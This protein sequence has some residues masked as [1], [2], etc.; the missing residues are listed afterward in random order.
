MKVKRTKRIEGRGILWNG[1]E[2][3]LY[4]ASRTSKPGAHGSKVWIRVGGSWL[5]RRAG[6]RRPL[7]RMLGEPPTARSMDGIVGRVRI[8]SRREHAVG[9]GE[10][11]TVIV[12]PGWTAS[13]GMVSLRS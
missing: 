7:E 3:R 11:G 13:W 6:G 5:S 9:T 12:A 2:A 8:P 10:I 4:R 1:Q